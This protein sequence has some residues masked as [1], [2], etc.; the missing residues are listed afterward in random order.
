[1]QFLS[2]SQNC[3]VFR[4]RILVKIKGPFETG[5]ISRQERRTFAV[6]RNAISAI[7][8][9]RIGTPGV[10]KVKKAMEKYQ[11]VLHA[12]KLTFRTLLYLLWFHFKVNNISASSQS[13]ENLSYQLLTKKNETFL[14]IFQALCISILQSRSFFSAIVR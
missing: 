8:C 14:R 2:S 10:M 12:F 6:M 4:I 11:K 5:G 7:C 3:V 9:R 1:M 13:E